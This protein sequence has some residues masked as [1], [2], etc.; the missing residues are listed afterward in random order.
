MK[1]ASSQTHG[2]YLDRG[3]GRG[4]LHSLTSGTYYTEK[5]LIADLVEL[6]RY[7][8]PEDVFPTGITIKQVI[9]MLQSRHIS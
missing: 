1:V 2:D 5:E 8:G 9:Q 4:I 7:L 6:G 3:P